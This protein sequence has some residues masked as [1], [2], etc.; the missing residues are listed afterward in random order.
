MF[1]IFELEKESLSSVNLHY[2]RDIWMDQKDLSNRSFNGSNGAVPFM[3]L[4]EGHADT[5]LLQIVILL[6]AIK[7][8]LSNPL[9]YFVHAPRDSDQ[10]RQ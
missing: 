4:F 9:G 3:F 10:I 1:S 2:L 6:Q 5:T 7:E 8:S